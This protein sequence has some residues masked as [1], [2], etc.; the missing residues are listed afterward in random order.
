MHSRLLD[1][2]IM[3]RSDCLFINT[4]NSF[5]DLANIRIILEYHIRYQQFIPCLPD[6]ITLL[7]QLPLNL[8][9]TKIVVSPSMPFST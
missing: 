9:G 7:Y 1:P 8:S 2:F 4:Y 6:Q 5:Q 3:S